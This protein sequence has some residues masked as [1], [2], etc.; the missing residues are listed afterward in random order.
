MGVN[1]LGKPYLIFDGAM[2]TMLQRN[3]LEPGQ[4]PE[5]FNIIHP[6]IIEKIHRLYIEAGSDIITTNTF[7]ANEIRLR[8]C[9]Y[10]VEEVVKAAVRIA[11]NAA[12][13]KLVALDIGPTGEFLEPVGD[14]T[15]ERAYDIFSKQVIAGA[16]EGADIILI[17]TFSSLSEAECAVKAAKKNSSLPV[18]CTFTFQKDRRTFMGHDV[19]SVVSSLESWGVD[20]VGVN[21]SV[22]PED[23]LPVVEEMLKYTGLPV[24]VQPNAGLPEFEDGKVV[25]DV[26]AEGFAKVIKEMATMGA[27]IFGGCCGTD[28]TFIKAIRNIL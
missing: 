24:V 6:E 28:P 21:C 22:G 13:D 4:K 9:Q 20:A 1:F 10:S 27:K 16:E 3:G 5:S 23:I 26:T 14:L 19:K 25:Y 8:G 11:R 18:I 15:Y 2:G 17:E 12:K 7:G